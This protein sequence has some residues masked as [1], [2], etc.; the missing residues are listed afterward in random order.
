MISKLFLFI[1]LCISMTLHSQNITISKQGN[2]NIYGKIIDKNSQLPLPYV[3]ITIKEN[4]KIVTGTITQDNGTFI[5][6]NLELKSYITEIQFIGYKKLIKTINLTANDK[7]INFNTILLEEEATQ[8]KEVEIVSEKSILEQKIDRKVINVGKD[9]ISAGATAGE[10]MNN[11]P[12]VTVDPQTNAISLR[13]NENVRI[14]ID[15]KPTNLSSEQI[16]QQIPS[17]SI[18]Q[19]ELI[20]NPS[21]KY[22]PEGMS[23]II[24]IVLHKNARMGFNGSINTGVTF[25]VTPKANSSFDMNYRAGKF[26]FYG[27]YGFNH[28]KQANDGY[29]NLFDENNYSNQKFTFRNKNTSHL[30]KFGVDYFLNEKN[31]ISVYTNQSWF[32]GEGFGKTDVDYI[33]GSN[34]DVL[35]LLDNRIENITETYNL[36]YI[37]HFTKEGHNIELEVNYNKNDG[38]ENAFFNFPNTGVNYSNQIETLG[39]NTILNLDYTNPLNDK[40]KVELG[41]ES[42]IEKTNNTFD[43]NYLYYSNFNFKR[44]IY[45]AY[46]TYGQQFTKWSYQIGTRFEQYDVVSNFYKTDDEDQNNNSNT[47]EIIKENYKDAIFTAYP[48]AYFSYTPNDKNS[49]NFNY[50]RRVDRP[51]IGQVNPIRDWSTPTL[52]SVGEPTLAPQFTNS[53]ELNYTRKSKIGSITSGIF[54]RMIVDEITRAVYTDPFDENRQI[55]SYQN[56]SKNNAL[57]A[58]V[59]GNLNF[60]KW[61][62]ANLGLDVYFRKINGTIENEFNEIVSASVNATI[63]NARINNNIKATKNLR[64]QWFAMYRGEDKSLQYTRKPMWKTDIG[65]SL[66]VIKGNGTISTRVSDIFNAM[67]FE[68]IGSKPTPR[69]GQ[70]N[71]ESRTVYL[72]FNYKF[73]TGKNRALQRKQR[74]KNETQGGGGLM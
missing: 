41:V 64:F 37:H 6:K 35:Q 30:G 60:T 52:T 39:D 7:S 5:I 18:K 12:S 8:L 1:L 51:S 32:I 21:A 56:F 28:G 31:T 57:G 65:A 19:I 29:V 62:S 71:W 54:Y 73:G 49:F 67:R 15:G 45:S 43:V 22:N 66:N 27:N 61:W 70:F 2:G 3:N 46:A 23:G 20:T 17:A 4:D 14:L 10:I 69:E 13:G 25:G 40:T 33:S 74:D 47:T 48:S 72:G 50:S 9:L 38:P 58:E 34:A 42:R 53:F 36:D 59:S 16:L 24:N 68:L 55:L 26:N 44:T 11:I 63:F